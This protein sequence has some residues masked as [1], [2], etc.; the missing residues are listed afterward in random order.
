MAAKADG[1]R[2]GLEALSLWEGA[3]IG[4]STRGSRH[5]SAAESARLVV[6]VWRL[7][8]RRRAAWWSDLCYRQLRARPSS[9]QASLPAVVTMVLSH[10]LSHQ[11]AA[12]VPVIV[13]LLAFAAGCGGSTD[14]KS[15]PS[16]PPP[17]ASPTNRAGTLET[18]AGGTIHYEC[19]GAGSPAI[20]LEAG[21]DSAGSEQYSTSLFDPLAAE[22]TVC[23]YD[24]PGTGQSPDL[25]DHRRT[26]DDVCE[27]QGQVI[28]AL[29]IPSPYVLAGQ[30]A[31]GNM[32]IG[33][34][35]RHPDRLAGLVVIEGYHDD[36]REM[37]KESRE[38]GYTW[39]DNPEHLDYL[40]ITD[41]LDGMRMP[42]GT[43]PVLVLTA[44]DAD[45]GNVKNQKYWVGL[46]ST[47][48]QV[49]VDGSHDLHDDNPAVIASEMLS[50]LGT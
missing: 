38:E 48:R 31:G 11:G 6:N 23:T 43:F 29:D 9:V 36:P 1:P 20:I 32:V 24:R 18:D 5:V 26:L 42:I 30:S 34:A 40:D 17:T 14:D 47:S 2:S 21:S 4:M 16:T 8:P 22:T 15:E 39:E 50:L 28:D 19:F 44:T 27:V 46:S 25:P 41:E 45:P 3:L 35:Q 10:R 49:V 13:I 33:C 7:P 37:R 12:R